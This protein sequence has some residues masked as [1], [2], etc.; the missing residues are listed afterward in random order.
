MFGRYVESAC[1]RVSNAKCLVDTLNVVVQE[2][3]MEHVWLI[4]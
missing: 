3:Q 2:Y 1:T 4:R